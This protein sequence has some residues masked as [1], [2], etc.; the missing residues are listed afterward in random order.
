MFCE[1]KALE[2]IKKNDF[3]LNFWELFFVFLS[4]DKETLI[5]VLINNI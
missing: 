3:F 4:F 5:E 1:P 2:R